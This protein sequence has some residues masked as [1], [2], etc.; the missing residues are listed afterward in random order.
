MRQSCQ[1]ARVAVEY[2]RRGLVGTLTLQ[3]NTTVEPEGV[4]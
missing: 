4:P 3:A 1:E 2:A